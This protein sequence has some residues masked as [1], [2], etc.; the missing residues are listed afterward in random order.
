YGKQ[1]RYAERKGIPYVWFVEAEG[2]GGHEVRDIRSGVQVA[3]AVETW[4]PNAADV[5]VR[6]EGPGAR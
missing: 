5:D 2:S 3:A 4:T 1:I 6:L